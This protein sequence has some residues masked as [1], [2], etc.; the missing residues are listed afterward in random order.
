MIEYFL[1]SLTTYYGSD[2]AAMVF[3]FLQL[4][5]MAEKNKWGFIYGLCAN[6]CWITFGIIAGSV[7]SPFANIIFAAL[8]IRG[9]IK[10][11]KPNESKN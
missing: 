1:N 7:A 9:L 3:T 8:N 11:H 4:Y 5:L 2:W 10:W 6:V